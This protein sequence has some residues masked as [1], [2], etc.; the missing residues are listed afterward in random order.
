[1]NDRRIVHIPILKDHV[2]RDEVRRDVIRESDEWRDDRV[3]V[4][5]LGFIHERRVLVAHTIC[6]NHSIHT[7]SE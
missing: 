7:H 4:E 1:M 2:V 5:G 3:R 6:L